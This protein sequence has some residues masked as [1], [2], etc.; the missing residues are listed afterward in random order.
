MNNEPGKENADGTAVAR[1]PRQSRNLAFF[2]GFLRRPEVVGS[3]IPSSRFLERRIVE[4]ASLGSASTVVELGPGTGG[5][6]AALLSE[7]SATSRLLAIETDEK[8]V[9]LLEKDA[10]PRLAAHLGSAADLNR[11]LESH[12]LSR[13]EVIISGIPFS[14]M[15]DELGLKILSAVHDCLPSGGRFVAY[16]FRSRVAQLGRQVMGEPE[17]IKV[18][19][20]VPPMSVYRWVKA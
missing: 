5:T 3:I 7:M 19:R 20:N 2:M 6:T 12:G 16:Q 13:P 11:I 8:F 18:L 1:S 17:E 14:T 9:E 4:A 15:P 10:D